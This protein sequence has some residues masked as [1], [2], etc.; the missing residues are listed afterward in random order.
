VQL[1]AVDVRLPPRLN[2]AYVPGVGDNVAPMLQ[3]LGVP[4]T[5]LDPAQLA[6]AD[7]SRFTTIVVGPRAYEASEALRA[8]NSR[9]LDWVQRGGTMVVQYGQ[10]EMMQPGMTPYPVTINRPHDRV[11]DETAPVRT[12]LPGNSLLTTPNRIAPADFEGWVQERAL[13]MPRTF[14]N[15][16]RPLF[17]MNDPGEQANN[18]AL[19]VAAYGRGTYVYTTLSLFRQ[20]PAGVP[21]AARLFANLLGAR[22][23]SAARAQP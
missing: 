14:A 10:Y 13:Y 23:E 11:T 15:Q 20:L 1:E 4:L 7:L 8:N 18:G 6:G 17:S 12:L 21:G 19:L 9:L 3:Q 22:A 2:V 16:Y 5:L